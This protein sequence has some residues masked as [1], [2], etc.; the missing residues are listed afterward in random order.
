[1]LSLIL[2]ALVS[3]APAD[4]PAPEAHTGKSGQTVFV[5]G[6]PAAMSDPTLR[7]NGSPVALTP[8]PVSP[9]F[10]SYALPSGVKVNPGDTLAIGDLPVRNSAGRVEFPLPD[11]KTMGLGINMSAF[12]RSDGTPFTLGRNWAIRLR[13][14]NWNGRA[15]TEFSPE[16][17]PAKIRGQEVTTPFLTTPQPGLGGLWTVVYDAADRATAV[18]LAPWADA[19]WTIAHRPD[20]SSPGDGGRGI[21]RVFE[22]TPGGSKAPGPTLQLAINHPAGA[23]TVGNLWII[24]P[25]NPPARP[26][27][28]FELDSGISSKLDLGGGKGPL[29]VRMMDSTASY[30]GV[31]NVVD[32]ADLPD[33]LRPRSRTVTAP[34]ARVRPLDLAVSPTI[35]TVYG[36][37]K[38][39]DKKVWDLGWRWL[40]E[41]V[42]EAPHGLRTGQVATVR[43]GTATPKGGGNP[44][45][46]YFA[47]QVWVTSPTTFA[48]TGYGGQIP[49]EGP[50]DLDAAIE[51]P[52][53]TATVEIPPGSPLSFEQLAATASRW[54]GCA[55]WVSI[56]VAANDEC[57]REIARRVLSRLGSTN[58]VI[59]ELSNETWNWG[60]PQS[61]YC[62]TMSALMGLPRGWPDYYTARRAAECAAEFAS[63]FSR[64]G[65]AGDV[66]LCLAGQFGWMT[67]PLLSYAA[68]QGIKADVVA[69]APYMALG[70]PADWS[71]GVAGW[72]PGQLHDLMRHYIALDPGS[73]AA[74]ADW[75]KSVSE[76]EAA[77]GR[78]VLRYSYEGGIE[79][80]AG[81]PWAW[82]AHPDAG[83]TERCLFAACQ[84][85]GFD[86]LTYFSLIDTPKG[87]GS[88]WGLYDRQAQLPGRG[89]GSD[90]K[91]VNVLGGGQA[92]GNVSP[93]GEAW[94]DWQRDVLLGR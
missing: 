4:A 31:S 17:F 79:S 47:S 5:T 23:P 16:G 26:A 21:V 25:G 90:G 7:V 86:G 45:G 14:W 3:L 11:R 27:D 77:I 62:T 49:Q 94:R 63:V 89:D 71:A 67:R 36:P 54:Q 9:A 72:T 37:V 18:G 15:V 59:I 92:A 35:E 61:S 81:N 69:G 29:V 73:T 57:V 46:P 33:P 42:C 66:K 24:G 43:L 6:A 84:R 78:K 51:T 53:A 60:F 58:K 74:F 12:Y 8:G 19:D 48:F 44:L 76:Y 20:L 32:A 52:G 56:P 30:G 75:D 41:A 10:R 68:A 83:D 13:D 34:I 22:V 80:I 55:A 87:S 85:G 39:A 38:I 65:R 88:F 64:A 40:G 28:P 50:L 91:A 70:Y 93:R 2:S 1:M 82:A